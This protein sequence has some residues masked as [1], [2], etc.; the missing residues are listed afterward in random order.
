MFTIARFTLLEAVR[1]RLFI[2]IMA[3]VIC[4]FVLAEFIGELSITETRQVQSAILSSLLRV[5]SISIISLFVITSALRE[6]NDKGLEIILSLPMPRHQYL[7]GKLLGYGGLSLLISIIVSLPLLLYAPTIPVICWFLSLFCEQA[8]V[9][10]LSLVCLFT[11]A[12]VTISFVTISF[13]A[14]MAFYFLSRSMETIRLLS[15]SPI[16]ESNAFSQDFIHC[17]VDAMALL[18][19]DLSAFTKSDWLAYN[20]DFADMQ[21]VII[22]TMI[23]LT[24]LLSAG[25]FDLYRKNI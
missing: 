5:F 6:L 18:L 9:I 4:L 11:F 21:I 19:P 16:L 1:N 15:E 22:Q 7:F 12:N 23:Y 20:V 2:L 24:I 10:S 8:L 25:L 17:L 14:V 3:G 13:I